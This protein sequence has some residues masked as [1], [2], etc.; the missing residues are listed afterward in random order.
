MGARIP[1]WAF[2]KASSLFTS[3]LGPKPRDRLGDALDGDDLD[4]VDFLLGL[5]GPGDDR[6]GEAELGGL[7]QP[8]LA[9]RG[10]PRPRGRFRRTPRASPAAAC[11]RARRRS[12][13]A[14]RGPRRAR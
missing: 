13:A 5:I 6:L 11:R 3:I 8:L 14:P 4:P 2:F 1:G 7:L 12:R 9:A 10:A